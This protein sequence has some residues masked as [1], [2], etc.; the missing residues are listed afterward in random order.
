MRDASVF[1]F[2][3]AASIAFFS[4]L[5]AHRWIDARTA[6]RRARERFALLRK[7]ADQPTDAVQRVIDLV[8]EDDAREARREEREREEA[9][10]EELKGGLILVAAGI[11]ISI[12]LANLT[13]AKQ[14]WAVGLIPGFVGVVVFAFAYF[15]KGPRTEA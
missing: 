13:A 2:L 1:F 3:A 11:G 10:R 5:A 4:F 15:K 14:L 6:E 7:L 12:M 9:R 8:R